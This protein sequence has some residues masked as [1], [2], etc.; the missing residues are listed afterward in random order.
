MIFQR[1]DRILRGQQRRRFTRA[2]LA[3][4]AN[5]DVPQLHLASLDPRPRLFP[6]HVAVRTVRIAEQVHRARCILVA[7]LNPVARL[8]LRPDFLGHWRVDQFLQRLAAQV[9]TVGVVQITEQNVFAIRSQVQGHATV[10]ILRRITAQTVGRIELADDF[11]AFG[12]D[13]F[14]RRRQF[15][16]GLHRRQV[17]QGGAQSQRQQVAEAGHG[18]FLAEVAGAVAGFEFGVGVSKFSRARAR[19]ALDNSPR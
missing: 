12:F 7:V 16:S 15:F 9:L 1:L 10:L 19:L 18:S 2:V 8:E 5:H 4:D 14:D 6:E 11:R 17:Q 13:L 3:N